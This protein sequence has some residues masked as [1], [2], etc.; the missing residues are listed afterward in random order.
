MAAIFRLEQHPKTVNK[1]YVF[2]TFHGKV[3]VLFE[4]SSNFKVRLADDI[5]SRAFF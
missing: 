1:H 3:A 2:D 5:S 4:A